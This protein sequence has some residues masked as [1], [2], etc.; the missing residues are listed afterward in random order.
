MLPLL[1]NK[2]DHLPYA[3]SVLCCGV[4]LCILVR[5]VSP[6]GFSQSNERP[7]ITEYD[8]LLG[9]RETISSSDD[10]TFGICHGQNSSQTL[11]NQKYLIAIALCLGGVPKAMRPLFSAYIQH[12]ADLNP[13]QVM[14]PST[15]YHVET[16]SKMLNNT[17]AYQLCLLQGSLS[18]IILILGFPC[19]L[20][21]L[22][23]GAS[24]RPSQTTLYGAKLGFFLMGI[25]ALMIGLAGSASLLVPGLFTKFHSIHTPFHI[26]ASFL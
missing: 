23:S 2:S 8:A 10:N 14:T 6:S 17:Q 1:A 20:C 22:Q 7:D 3:L 4:S 9:P 24:V 26:V 16:E 19:V 18:V 13:P 15:H 12:R 11:V 25:G 21:L 5:I